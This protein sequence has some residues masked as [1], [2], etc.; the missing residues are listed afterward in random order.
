MTRIADMRAKYADLTENMK[1]IAM[2]SQM[3]Q[4]KKPG[5]CEN[6]QLARYMRN[7]S[8]AITRAAFGFVS[9]VAYVRV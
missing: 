7:Q 5:P 6:E 9:W 4:K 3:F 1:K 2:L 8:F